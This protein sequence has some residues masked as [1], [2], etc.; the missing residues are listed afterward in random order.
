MDIETFES[1]DDLAQRAAEEWVPTL[2]GGSSPYLAAVS[3]GRVA[4]NFF[5]AIARVAD[6]GDLANVHFFWADERCVVPDHA[7][8]NYLLAKSNLFELADIPEAQ[9]H[10]LQGELAPADGAATGEAELREVANC[11][12]GVPVLD[13][14]FL[15]MG[16]DGHVASLFPGEDAAAMKDPAIFRPV[17]ASKPPPNR[18][19]ISYATIAAAK[20]VWVLASGIGKQ[21]ALKNSLAEDG[22]TPLARVIQLRNG[23]VRI[24]TDFEMAG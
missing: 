16:E 14:V 10:R 11:P 13:I 6:A 22:N 12:T 21:E 19:T 17:V 18:I 4:K 20:E 9:V 7:D 5:R 23:N 24:L 8:S 15:G 1:A 3:G 2:K